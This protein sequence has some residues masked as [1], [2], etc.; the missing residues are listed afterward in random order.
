MNFI[1]TLVYSGKLLVLRP[2]AASPTC[3]KVCRRQPNVWHEA[4]AHATMLPLIGPSSASTASAPAV[5]VQV[6]MPVEP[7]G[8]KESVGQQHALASHNANRQHR[9]WLAGHFRRWRAAWAAW[10]VLRAVWDTDH[11]AC[12]SCEHWSKG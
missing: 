10:Y 5:Q 8:C 4:K 11:I 6:G 9:T 1:S 2:H 7:A 12:S 3:W